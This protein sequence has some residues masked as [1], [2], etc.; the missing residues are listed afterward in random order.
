MMTT[1]FRMRLT[2]LLF[3]AGILL[4]LVL[5]SIMD[6]PAAPFSPSDDP[7]ER[8]AERKR[9]A[10]VREQL[11]RRDITDERVL[12]A[13]RQ[14]KRHLLVPKAWRDL[15]YVDSPLPIGHGQTISQ[16][17]IVALMTQLSRPGKRDRAL[18]VGTGSGYQAAVLAGLVEHVYSVEIICPLADAARARLQPLGYDNV[19]V[20]CGDGYGGWPE[21]APFDV[22][23]VA[24]AAD[25]IPQPLIDQLAAGGRLVIPVGT[26]FQDL[27]IVEK[28]ADG[29]LKRRSVA[30]V[31]F[32]PMTRMSASRSRIRA[33][34]DFDHSLI[35][36]QRSPWVLQID[37]HNDTTRGRSGEHDAF[38][39]FHHTVTHAH[40]VTRF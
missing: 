18:D 25:Q 23:I 27:L 4:A 38:N 32:V 13:M 10:M 22:I 2:G 35:D 33:S 17:Y 3:F 15:A 11:A 34:D 20:R 1:W 24:A 7:F 39:G 30:P 14:V 28:Q 8:E 29:T 6:K 9:L 31:A 5:A 16:P 19:D 40:S 37:R 21:H 36:F 26:Y 12:N